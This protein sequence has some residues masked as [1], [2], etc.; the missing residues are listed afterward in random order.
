MI[1][2]IECISGRELPINNN[3]GN[4]KVMLG[5]KPEFCDAQQN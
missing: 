4:I 5:Q 3:P 1:S 2:Q